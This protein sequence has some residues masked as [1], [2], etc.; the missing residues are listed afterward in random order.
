MNGA[1]TVLT[2]TKRAL[3]V[4]FD[5]VCVCLLQLAIFMFCAIYARYPVERGWRTLKAEKCSTDL[6]KRLQTS[7]AIY[8]FLL[9]KKR[10]ENKLHCMQ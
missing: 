6:D 4:T 1:A 5:C 2:V 3:F 8:S 9:L 10:K 7:S